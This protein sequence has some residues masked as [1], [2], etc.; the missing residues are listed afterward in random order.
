MEK[1][2]ACVGVD[3]DEFRPGTYR[4]YFVEQQGRE[5]KVF[6]GGS[7]FTDKDN[8]YKH[9]HLAAE[10]VYTLSSASNFYTDAINYFVGGLE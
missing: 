1:S 6:N 9:A 3:Y 2:V 7:V 5:R 4:G 10:I 8:A